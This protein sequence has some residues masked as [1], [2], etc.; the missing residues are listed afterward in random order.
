[1][2]NEQKERLK[3]LCSVGAIENSPAIYRR[4]HFKRRGESR[5]G[6]PNL[7]SLPGLANLTPFLPHDKSRGY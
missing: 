5:Q 1:M 6:R 2:G 4:E 7:S 3:V